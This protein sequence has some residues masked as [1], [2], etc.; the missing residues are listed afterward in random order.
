MAGEGI[1]AW[2]AQAGPLP[3]CQRRV[4]GNEVREEILQWIR[5]NLSPES[6]A[7]FDAESEAQAW[8]EYWAREEAFEEEA[9]A[10]AEE[11]ALD[12][13]YA[14][15]LEL[16]ALG[17]AIGVGVLIGTSVGLGIEYALTPNTPSSTISPGCKRS[18]TPVVKGTVTGCYWGGDR[19]LAKTINDAEA[20]C[21]A[22]TGYCTGACPGGKPCVP[23]ALVFPK[24]DQ[25]Y[26]WTGYGLGD[27][28]TVDYTCI[29]GC[30]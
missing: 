22:L 13:L 25:S 3:G 17:L 4:R 26:C 16:G 2:A 30:Q 21:N 19:S 12:D 20:K 27:E 5:E 23:T 29:C 14:A 1:L 18:N 9:W 15:S 11:M 8:E 28:T 6:E 24:G 10:A 7:E